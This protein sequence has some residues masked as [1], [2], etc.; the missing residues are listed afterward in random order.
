M[1]SRRSLVLG[2]AA[3]AVLAGCGGSTDRPGADRPAA[4]SGRGL[5]AIAAPVDPPLAKPPVVMPA[6]D[7]SP[8][9]LR[10]DTAGRLTLLFFGFTNCPDVCPVH[11]GVLAGALDALRR[12]IERPLVLFVAVDPARDRPD[13]VRSFLDTFSRNFIGLTPEPPV[14]ASTLDALGLPGITLGEPDSAGRYSV[15]HPTQILAFSPDGLCRAA[16]PF[17]TRRQDWVSDLPV[18]AAATSSGAR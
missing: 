15:G 9:D 14:I 3:S 11:L 10:A 18:L 12:D 4:A 16:Y 6:T 7:G 2:A 13:R 17:G 8:F 5:S 1:I